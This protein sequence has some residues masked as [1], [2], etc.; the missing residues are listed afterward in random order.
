MIGPIRAWIFR[1]LWWQ[2]FFWE[3]D[4]CIHSPPLFDLKVDCLFRERSMSRQMRTWISPRFV[5][6]K[7]KSCSVK[8]LSY[9]V[10]YVFSLFTRAYLSLF[11]IEANGRSC[12]SR[13][14]SDLHAIKFVISL[15][16]ISVTSSPSMLTKTSPTCTWPA[17]T[18]VDRTAETW[19]GPVFDLALERSI[20]N[21]PGG[22]MSVK[23]VI[24]RGTGSAPNI[25]V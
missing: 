4:S 25:L 8:K 3:D 15:E 10:Y 19:V 21:F 5:C 22:A 17:R 20:P 16:F 18:L 14:N 2:A 1:S 12:N 7:N 9:I 11:Q 24:G 6:Y 23:Y 13:S